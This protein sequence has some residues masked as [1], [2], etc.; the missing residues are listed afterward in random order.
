GPV[1]SP[2]IVDRIQSIV[3]AH[4]V[5]GLSLAFVRSGDVVEYG[6]WGIRSE[7]GDAVTSDTLFTMAS[8]SKAFTAA[9]MGLLIEDYAA[10]RN[11]TPLPD[12]L[13]RLDWDTKLKDILP[14]FWELMDGSASEMA[15]VKDILSHQTGVPSRHDLSY[16][17]DDS[18]TDMAARLKYLRPAFEI[19]ERYH[20]NNIMYMTTQHILT[21][22]TGSFTDFVRDRIFLPLNMTSTTYSPSEAIDSGK[23]TQHWGNNGRLIPW[24]FQDNTTELIAGAGGI[25]SSAQDMTHWV[26]MLLNGGVDPATNKR[27]LSSAIIEAVTLGRTVMVGTGTS[28]TSIQAYGMGWSRGSY[29]GHELIQH[30]GGLPGIATL[31]VLSPHQGVGIVALSNGDATHPALNEA[32]ALLLHKVW[33]VQQDS[34]LPTLFVDTRMDGKQANPEHLS[35]NALEE[36][37]SYDFSGLYV[38]EGYGAFLLCDS[39]STS[40]HCTSVLDDFDAVDG[41]SKRQDGE[42]YA[43]WPRLWTSHLRMVY[44][45]DMR[46][47]MQ[48]TQLFVEGFGKN[49]TPFEQPSGSAYADFVVGDDGDVIGFGLFGLVGERTNLEKKGGS[50]QEIADVW[51]DRA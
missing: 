31:V 38:N 49:S 24:W 21:T 18:A 51:F 50:V 46:F 17:R 25:I 23:G 42:L 13:V 4:K 28:D 20:Y 39:K 40:A 8:C 12:G 5:P 36:L 14:G 2:D 34:A 6:N 48:A 15:S 32:A 26:Q 11:V 22:Y 30:N 9:A 1:L 16:S 27:I 7:A 41:P 44:T 29:R 3:N 35:G 43:A 37:P 19:R 33:G 10:G 45:G 47:V